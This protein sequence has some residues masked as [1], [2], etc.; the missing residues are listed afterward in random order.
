MSKK[1]LVVACLLVMTTV[2]SGCDLPGRD[3]NQEAAKE[4]TNTEQNQEG[5]KE[6]LSFGSMQDL[7]IHGKPLK[8]TYSDVSDGEGEVTGV[9]YIANN[10]RRTEFKVIEKET[11]KKLEMN[12]IFAGEWMYSWSDSTTEGMKMNI[13]EIKG[14]V[15]FEK[16]SQ[17]ETD[18]MK[19]KID[20]KCRPWI[21]DNSKFTVPLDVDFKD[22]TEI[23]GGFDMNEMK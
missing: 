21:I 6:E 13:K 12:S 17:G 19:K 10:K 20:Y 15:Q 7:L 3:K 5:D 1:I 14:D 22:M 2:F 4:G 18:T 16:Y 9:V 8:C 11:D 23:M